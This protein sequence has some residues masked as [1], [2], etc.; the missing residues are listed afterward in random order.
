MY[1]AYFIIYIYISAEFNTIDQTILIKRLAD[2]TIVGIPLTWIKSY[3]S[4]KNSINTN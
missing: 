1:T 3:L 4:E 2:I